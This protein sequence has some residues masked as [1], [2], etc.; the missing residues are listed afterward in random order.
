MKAKGFTLIEVMMALAILAVVVMAT[1]QILESTMNAK[2]ASEDTL[3]EL[4][5]LQTVFRFMDQDFSQLS[6]RIVRNESGD[7]ATSYIIHGRYQFESQYDGIG[8]IRDGWI[9]PI[10]LLPRSELQAVGYRVMDDKLERLYRIYVDQLDGTEPKV[11]VL[12]N[13]VEELK[14]EFLD[15]AQKWQDEWKMQALPLA[16]AVTLKQK[17][18]PEIRRIFAVPGTGEERKED[19]GENRGASNG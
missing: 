18:K 17:D 3:T 11:Q 10:N 14:F 7:K 19:N 6:T 15:K 8:F 4:E 13:D 12:L 9:N 16:V 2:E 5:K 1:H